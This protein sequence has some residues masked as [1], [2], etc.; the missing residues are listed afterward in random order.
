ML[1]FILRH[2]YYKNAAKTSFQIPILKQ[3]YKTILQFKFKFLAF[4][5]QGALKPHPQ[6]SDLGK[7]YFQKR[8]IY[9]DR[10]RRLTTFLATICCSSFQRQIE[11]LMNNTECQLKDKEKIA[12][13]L[14]IYI[15][16]YIYGLYIY[17]YTHTYIY[18]TYDKLCECIY[19]TKY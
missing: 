4:L 7:K 12:W 16:K 11:L 19:I 9:L 5:H 13:T 14:Y 1:P 8:F 15:Y 3:N 17:I 10:E 2:L 18:T 6:R